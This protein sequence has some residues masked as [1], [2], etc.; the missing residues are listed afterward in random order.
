M[1]EFLEIMKH[2]SRI[3]KRYSGDEHQCNG[4]PLDLKDGSCLM[5][6]STD[7][8]I[9]DYENV[10]KAVLQWVEE[11]PEPQYPTWGEWQKE[12]FPNKECKIYPCA[13]ESSTFFKNIYKHKCMSC[14]ACIG[15]P[16]PA[17]IAEK[18]SIKPIPADF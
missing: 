1:A 3:C 18:L 12:N 15:S 14:D 17:K 6:D 10:E 9:E 7:M 2:A 4:C 8:S 16:I 5:Y 11:H 13:F